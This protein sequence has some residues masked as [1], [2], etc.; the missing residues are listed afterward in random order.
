MIERATAC[1]E[2]AAHHLLRRFEVPT[3]SNRALL[4]SFW[5]HGGDDLAG[6]AWWPEYLFNV[7]RSSQA[8]LQA[9]RDVLRDIGSSSVS[10]LEDTGQNLAQ[11]LQRNHTQTPRFAPEL[12]SRLDVFR[13][14]R[15]YTQSCRRFREEARQPEML[16][17]KAGSIRIE[18]VNQASRRALDA[19]PNQD[20]GTTIA[21][22]RIATPR[23]RVSSSTNSFRNQAT[24]SSGSRPVHSTPD[25]LLS[26]LQ[27]RDDAFD[28]AWRLFVSLQTPE[29]FARRMLQYLSRSKRRV[30]HERAVRAYK[31][32]S[33]DERRERTYANAMRVANS[34]RSQRL[35]LEINHEALSRSLGS[36]SSKIFFGYL[37]RNNLWNTLAQA[38]DD[39]RGIQKRLKASSYLGG[40]QRTQKSDY[41]AE[42]DDRFWKGLWAEADELPNLPEKVLLLMRRIERASPLSL[43]TQPRVK[44]LATYLLY[45]IVQ[46]TRI[47]GM[48]NGN[49]ILSLFQ[50]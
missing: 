12:Q 10:G 39:V 14:D 22:A 47:M 50:Q 20:E 35:A 16:E 29:T 24:D 44:R 4:H 28:Q 30:D 34:R 21:E 25:E 32:L 11:I 37:V 23:R 3:R 43:L 48:I 2:P 19:P 27:A 49:G 18:K 42:Q 17:D 7:R 1:V 13:Q 6:P 36:D 41:L 26:L 15:S 33:P 46:S 40:H 8:Q 5:K 31:M 45:R 9:G 38:L